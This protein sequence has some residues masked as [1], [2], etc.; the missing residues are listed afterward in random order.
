MASERRET[1]ERLK[2]F[3]WEPVPADGGY[4]TIRLVDHEAKAAHDKAR[5][6]HFKTLPLSGDGSFWVE[7]DEVQDPCRTTAPEWVLIPDLSSEPECILDLPESFRE[8]SGQVETVIEDLFDVF[9]SPAVVAET[10]RARQQE[11]DELLEL[12]EPYI[13]PPGRR[14]GLFDALHVLAEYEYPALSHRRR[15]IDDRTRDAVRNLL[16]G[17]RR[18]NRSGVVSKSVMGLANGGIAADQGDIHARIHAGEVP[19]CDLDVEIYEELSKPETAMTAPGLLDHLRRLHP[20]D[21]TYTED[22]VEKALKKLKKL[23]AVSNLRGR[24]YFRTDNTLIPK[25]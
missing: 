10:K 16:T 7:D 21:T 22:R 12:A 14:I 13:L 6:E 20:H 17:I 15:L 5:F 11:I 24:G 9:A 23:R 8:A 3:L 1:V 4:M 2:G 18:G 25:D 19:L